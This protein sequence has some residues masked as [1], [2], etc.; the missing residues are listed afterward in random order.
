MSEKLMF[1]S[2]RH[3]E[4]GRL[5]GGVA[6][7]QTGQEVMEQAGYVHKYG[8]DILRPKNRAFALRLAGAMIT[9]CKN[10]NIGYDQNQRSGIIKYGVDSKTPTEADCG[11][12]VRAC[13]IKA[14]MDPGEFYTG[15][16]RKVLLASGVFDYIPFTGLDSLRVG[17][18]LVT[19]KKGHTVIVTRGRTRNECYPAYKG[20]TVSIIDAL[21]AV[22]EKDTS[23]KHRA[24]IADQNNIM[25]YSGTAKQNR[26]MLQ[27][28]KEGRLE[29]V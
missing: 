20:Y 13:C 24:L 25:Y 29:K 23:F 19:K 9:A 21:K 15:N 3:D 1:G 6:G 2:A 11:T 10:K 8:W 28:L 5:T 17:D 18:V 16:E 12:T 22:G 4:R 14:G 26:E 7:D 27:L